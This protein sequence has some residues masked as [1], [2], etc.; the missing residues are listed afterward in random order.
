MLKKVVIVDFGSQVTQLIAR[1]V[2]SQKVYC[3]VVP[4]NK[5][6]LKYIKNENPVGIILSGSPLSV[7]KRGFPSIKREIFFLGIPIL[8]ICYGMQLISSALGGKIKKIS[9]REY[10]DT[11]IRVIKKSSICPNNWKTKTK[12]DVWMSHG[13]SVKTLPKNFISFA[14]SNNENFVGIANEKMKIFG[15]QFHPEVTH[16]K[17]GKSII[18]KFLFEVC[19][20]KPQWNMKK[21][22]KENITLLINLIPQI[23]QGLQEEVSRP[24]DFRIPSLFLFDIQKEQMEKLQKTLTSEKV[25]LNYLS[26]MVRARLEKVN[27]K[28]FVYSDKVALTREQERQQSFRRRN[29]NLSYRTELSDSE[30]IVEGRMLATNYDWDSGKPAEVSLEVRYAERMGLINKVVEKTHLEQYV[31]D[32]A[33]RIAINAPLTVMASKAAINE[34][35]KNFNEQNLDVIADMV[36]NCFRSEDYKEGRNAFMEKRKPNFKGK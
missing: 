11:S 13:D 19:K 3:E 25:H 2:R 5:F 34:G 1:S 20:C 21:F 10:G 24:D 8:G 7:T 26:P 9:G 15:L 22:K 35:L 23:Y 16:T 36:D 27:G 31:V 14:K 29:L 30:H 18:K 33:S 4:F 32:F 12:H 17:D 6:S 28:N